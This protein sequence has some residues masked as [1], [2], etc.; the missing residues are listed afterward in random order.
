VTQARAIAFATLVVGAAL[1]GCTGAGSDGGAREFPAAGASGKADVLG[2]KLAGVAAPYEA[3]ELDDDVMRTDQLQR[4]TAAWATALKVLEE[5]PLLGL[6]ESAAAHEEIRLPEGEV[7]RVPRFETW[8]GIDDVKR[9]FV[10]LY[11]GLGASGR[12]AREGFGAAA[13][14]A[15]LKWNAD[16]LDRSD[17]WPLERY[18]DFVQKLGVCTPGA[19]PD[20]CAREV[21][22]SFGGAVSGNARILYSP[23]T[24]KHLLGNYAKVVDC[25]GGLDAVKLDAQPVDAANFSVCFGDEL[26]RDAVLVKAQW[27]RDLGEGLPT[28]DTDAA[29]LT[30]RLGNSA[31]WG[32]EGDRRA[33]PGADEI[34]TIRLRD[35]SVFRLAG[36]HIMTKELR[37]W[38][39]TTL[40]W[41]DKP[42][43]DFGADRPAVMKDRGGV[44]VN[45]KMCSVAWYGEDDAQAPDAPG[46]YA[47]APSLAAALRAVSGAT[48]GAPTWC[49]NPYLE[50]GRGNARSNC[51][52][53]H[54]HGGATVA[55][56]L[57]GDG[58]PDPFILEKVIADE[59]RFPDTGRRQLRKVFPAD[60]L[61]SFSRVDDFA[62]VMQSEIGYFE[63][64]D[65]DAVRPRVTHTLGLTGDAAAGA[66][67]YEGNC[68]RCHGVNGLGGGR[69]PSLADRVPMRE[70][71]ALLR[72]LIQGKGDMP[73]WGDRFED[74]A[75][76]DLL[77]HLRA[78]FGR[79][80]P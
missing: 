63:G 54:Q 73:R 64:A 29:A 16:A 79:P 67:L 7:P 15:A 11:E 42:D 76:A 10:H 72:T 44:F 21:A 13:I 41:S 32:E 25:L 17:R 31:D 30:R 40:W 80:Q 36:L 66:A 75:L 61:Y 52:G 2:R 1:L 26:P 45:Y 50:H 70:D 22:A 59:A 51:I 68:A 55:H 49:S 5:V 34:Y 74:Q 60:Y 19:A 6:A 77:A 69:A 9:V 53:C 18:L 56:D 27:V 47:G 28:W 65:A 48:A 20:V 37:H 35:G 57:D 62:H 8:Y 14:E 78:K 24:V 46:R 23:A 38:Q 4:R 39:W 3:A 33:Q 58:K 12:A 43:S 71:D